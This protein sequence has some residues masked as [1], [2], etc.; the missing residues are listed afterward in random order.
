M[1]SAKDILKAF[2]APINLEFFAFCTLACAFCKFVKAVF[3]ALTYSVDWP[4]ALAIAMIAFTSLSELIG[5]LLISILE[6][7]NCM[8]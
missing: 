3:N 7:A 4:A 8:R 2:E 1:D 5:L 6:S